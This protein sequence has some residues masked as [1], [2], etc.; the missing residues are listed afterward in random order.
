MVFIVTK[1]QNIGSKTTFMNS[2]K[3][4]CAFYAI[5]LIFNL[6][7]KWTL[8]LNFIKFRIKKQHPVA[9]DFNSFFC[10][11]LREKKVIP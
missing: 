3:K 2:I 6:Y 10:E 4:N 1:L 11:N 9:T 8:A 7:F 5:T